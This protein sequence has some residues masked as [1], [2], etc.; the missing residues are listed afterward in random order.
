MKIHKTK[1]NWCV[2]SSDLKEKPLMIIYTILKVGGDAEETRFQLVEVID[3]SNL[4]K[5]YLFLISLVI[6][7]IVVT[8]I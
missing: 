8:C 3:N 1:L 4:K 6:H 5:V 2:K 7:V